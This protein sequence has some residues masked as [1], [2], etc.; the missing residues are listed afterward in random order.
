MAYKYLLIEEDGPVRIIRLNRPEALN[1]LSTALMGELVDALTAFDEDE[2]VRCTVLTG[3]EKAFAAGADIRE[4]ADAGAIDMLKLTGFDHWDRLRKIKKPIIG[5]VNGFALGGGCE[6]AMN[7]DIL[8][9]SDTARF[10]QPEINI[11]VMPGAGGT[12]RLTHALGKSLA[13]ELV[14]TGRQLSADEALKHGLVSRVVPSS[15]LMTEAVKLAHEIAAKAPLAARLAKESVLKA[16]EMTLSEGLDYERRNFFFL[17]A[18]EDKQE[19][20][21][22]FLEKRSPQFKGS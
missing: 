13:M 16:Y 7:C 4:M 19:G 1:A 12:Q 11:G 17:F 10:G 14:L 3:S 21:K 2:A 18:S 6:L 20:M 15:E 5:A 8:I 9:A 22:A